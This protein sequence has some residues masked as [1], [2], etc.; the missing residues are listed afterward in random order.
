MKQED[1]G[2]YGGKAHE[3]LKT[4]IPEVVKRGCPKAC[5]GTWQGK[6]GIFYWEK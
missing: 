3:D 2:A 6:F 5:K 4:I 1:F